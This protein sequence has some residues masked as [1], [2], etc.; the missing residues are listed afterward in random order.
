MILKNFRLN[1]ICKFL[2]K[3]KTE[4]KTYHYV[5]NNKVNNKTNWIDTNWLN[6]KQVG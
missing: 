1:I 2:L 4:D 5:R 3:M 6:T